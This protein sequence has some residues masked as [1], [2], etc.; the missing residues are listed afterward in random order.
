MKRLSLP[1][2]LA[3]LGTGM[4]RT[5][6]A[7]PQLNINTVPTV[8]VV[9]NSIA[10]N[11]YTPAEWGPLIGTTR[12]WT[13]FGAFVF[14]ACDGLAIPDVYAAEGY[15]GKTSSEIADLMQPKDATEPWGTNQRIPV[16]IAAHKPDITVLVVSGNDLLLAK[17]SDIASGAALGASLEGL[18]DDIHRVQSLGSIPVVCN[19]TPIEGLTPYVPWASVPNDITDLVPTWNKEIEELCKTENVW[20]CDI[21]S[22]CA[23]SDGSNRWKDGFV[24]LKGSE[25]EGGPSNARK[26]LPSQM[27]SLAIAREALHPVLEKVIGPKCPKVP[28][29]SVTNVAPPLESWKIDWDREA[30]SSFDSAA[31][32]SS[33]GTN[34]MSFQK[35]TR[36][37]GDYVQWMSADIDVKPGQTFLY[38]VD[39]HI[40]CSDNQCSQR[41]AISDRT[42]GSA[43]KGQPL[44]C[45]GINCETTPGKVDTEKFRASGIFTIPKGITKINASF[46]IN[47]SKGGLD[48]EIDQASIENL[49]IEPLPSIQAAKYQ[50]VH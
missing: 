31:P 16:G 35:P 19:L 13:S 10:R 32:G 34:A 44:T 42:E 18:K 11:M 2:I 40:V 36:A 48:G 27:A 47:R 26:I 45:A 39:L 22:A 14:F 33:P 17:P 49:V 37:D 30:D 6:A 15:S 20:Y 23:K 25:V 21:F 41:F 1:L 4:L 3:L 46:S 12:E 28:S 43:S 24:Y 29:V 50:P 5:Q 8:S 7:P 9:G 38:A